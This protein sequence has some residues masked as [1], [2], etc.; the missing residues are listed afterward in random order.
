MVP[1][2]FTDVHTV[3]TR[4]HS[5]CNWHQHHWCWMVLSASSSV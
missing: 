3:I 2:V 1:S 4:L 5:N